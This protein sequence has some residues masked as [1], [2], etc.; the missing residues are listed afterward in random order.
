[1]AIENLSN[2]D[3]PFIVDGIATAQA[4]LMEKLMEGRAWGTRQDSDPP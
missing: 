2:P 1:M 4:A 3:Y